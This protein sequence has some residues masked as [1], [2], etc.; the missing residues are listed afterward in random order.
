MHVLSAT[1]IK[2]HNPGLTDPQLTELITA[3]IDDDSFCRYVI[4]QVIK[5]IALDLRKDQKDDFFCVPEDDLLEDF[6]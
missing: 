2:Q 4:Q 5:K 6:L 3:Y 1:I